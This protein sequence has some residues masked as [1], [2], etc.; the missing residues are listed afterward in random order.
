DDDDARHLVFDHGLDDA[1]GALGAGA[2]IFELGAAE[3]DDDGV[4]VLER[5]LEVACEDVDLDCGQ[6]GVVDG[7]FVR[8]ARPGE[9]VVAAGE[10][11][12]VGFSAGATGASYSSEFHRGLHGGGWIH[13]WMCCVWRLHGGS[14]TAEG[15]RVEWARQQR[16]PPKGAGV[17]AIY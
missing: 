14:S 5:G 4:D 2:A 1:L 6:L 8:C 17:E 15:A 11:L 9:D 13:W 12:M 7:E 3:A 10:G 16:S